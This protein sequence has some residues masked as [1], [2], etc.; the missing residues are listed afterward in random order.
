MVVYLVEVTT[1][2]QLAERVKTGKS[3]SKEDVIASSESFAEPAE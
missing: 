1:I 3:K 2:K